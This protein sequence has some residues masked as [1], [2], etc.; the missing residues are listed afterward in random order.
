MYQGGYSR[1]TSQYQQADLY[2]SIEDANPH[3]LVLM[4][5]DGLLKNINRV[6]N[7]IKENNTAAKC[8]SIKKAINILDALRSALNFEV[9]DKLA[10][11]LDELY[12]YMQRRL[13]A[14]NADSD[15]DA[16]HEVYTLLGEIRQAWQAIPAEDR[17]NIS[18]PT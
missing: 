18:N 4:L 14:V 11:N 2:G 7:A 6:D 15:L 5:Y 12:E 10:A 1:G 16:L 8:N 3:E 13:V 17:E 9:A